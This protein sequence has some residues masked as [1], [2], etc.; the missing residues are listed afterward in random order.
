MAIE[1]ADVA[2]GVGRFGEMGLL[3]SFAVA[4]KAAGTGL[5]PGVICEDEYLGFVAAT[6]HVLG[7][8]TV[9]GF[10][11]LLRGRRFLVQGGLP[12]G[13][14]LPTV[15]NLFVARLASVGAYEL[16]C[17]R[18]R[19]RGGFGGWL[20]ALTSLRIGLAAGENDEEKKYD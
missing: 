6:L 12:V 3:M 5:L 9:A 17:V 14:F 20:S 10:A 18:R 1:A 19:S 11:T 4:G 13:R 8:R 16:G 15:V 2:A 7:T